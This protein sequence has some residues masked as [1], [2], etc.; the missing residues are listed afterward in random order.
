ME[1]KRE[2]NEGG[3]VTGTGAAELATTIEARKIGGWGFCL[4]EEKEGSQVFYGILQICDIVEKL[5]VA[6][7]LSERRTCRT[8]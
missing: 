2:K 3:V 7:S 5:H 1:S 6:H 4:D 8:T